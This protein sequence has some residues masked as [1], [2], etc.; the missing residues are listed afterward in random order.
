MRILTKFDIRNNNIVKGINYEGVEKIGNSMQIYKNVC[1]FIKQNVTS[2]FEIILNDVTASLYNIKSGETDIKNILN[3]EKINLPH[4]CSGGINSIDEVDNKLNMN[5]DRIMINTALHDN[6]NLITEI[7]NI[8]GAQILIAS[9]ET[10]YINGDYY[11]YKNYGRED[12]NIKLI[13]WI[14]IL[15]NN[16]II[17]ILIISIDT[18]GTLLGYDKSLLNYLNKN[19]S[20]KTLPNDINYLYAGGISSISE[21]NEIENNY[22]FINGVSIS[23]LFYNNLKNLYFLSYIKG[24]SLSVQKYYNLKY[25]CI[26]VDS[27]NDIPLNETLCISGHYNSFKQIELIKKHND[28]NYLKKR[29]H[30]KTINYIGICSGLHILLETI[31]DENTTQKIDGFNILPFKLTKMNKPRI[32]FFNNKFYCHSY[33]VRDINNEIINTYI[34]D[35]I[36]VYQ[37][38]PENSYV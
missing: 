24:N 5:C 33:E 30:N 13:N 28:F 10:R 23:T 4:I 7:I 38:H 17:E 3:Y 16:G 1:N 29:L 26:Y 37:Y 19:I 12:T 32:G 25:N 6:I 8:Y 35:N 11:V 21:I 27:I 20:N 36:E 15:K 2:Q 18:D 9:I 34:K 31:N 22:T 14:N